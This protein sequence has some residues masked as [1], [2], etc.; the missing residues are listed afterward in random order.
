MVYGDKLGLS[1]VFSHILWNGVKFNKEGGKLDVSLKKEDGAV[2]V[3][4]SDTGIGISKDKVKT[5]F[6][7]FSQADTSTSRSYEG[8]GL[9]LFLARGL[10][11]MHDGVIGIKSESGEGTVVE[12]AIPLV[13]K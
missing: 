1:M 6:D 11:K 4:I 7:P 2:K 8:L 13:A 10:I 3:Y 12:V 9:G 5:I